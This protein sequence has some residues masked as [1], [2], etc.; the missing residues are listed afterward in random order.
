MCDPGN[1]IVVDDAHELELLRAFRDV[2]LQSRPVLVE[3][4]QQLGRQRN[5]RTIQAR[6]TT[7]M[8]ALRLRLGDDPAPVL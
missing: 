4:A 7:L 1:G 5:G 3:L 8:H 2:P 6:P